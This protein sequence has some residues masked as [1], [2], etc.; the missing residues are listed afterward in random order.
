MPAVVKN[1]IFDLGFHSGEDT[2]FYL[3]KGFSV[4]GVEA[5]PDL[6]AN[7]AVRFQDAI[8]QGRLHLISGAIAPASAGEKVVFYANPN[9][10]GWG[11]IMPDWSSRNE[12]FGY[13]SERIEV[14][15]V[16]IADVYRSHGIPFYLKIDVEGVDRLILEELASVDCLPQ[17]VSVESEKVDFDQLRGE[18]EL[19]K[20][21]GYK[22]FKVVQQSDIPGT[23]LRTCTIDGREFE[24]VFA[25]HTSGP[26]GGDLPSPWL[27]YAEALEEYRAV[28]RRY[29]YFGDQS[30][31]LRK[32]PKRAQQLARALYR[33]STGYKGPLPGWFDTHA[34]L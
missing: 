31:V 22:K 17:Y 32:L 11:T 25:P 6:V 7:A 9:N 1:L 28:F 5:N 14:P 23:K 12:M 24:Y 29:K 34:S 21:L 4:V 33:M 19:L 26:F 15:R 3:K 27:T 13:S 30:V 10:S 18:L 20:R 16:D 2:D 8:T